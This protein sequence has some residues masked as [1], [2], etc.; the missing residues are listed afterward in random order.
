MAI[1]IDKPSNQDTAQ[2][3]YDMYNSLSA[4]TE[5]KQDKLISGEN[6][7]TI[8]GESILGSGDIEIQGGGGAVI[9]LTQAEYNEITPESGITY[10]ITDSESI[11]MNDYLTVD[12][13]EATYAT[14]DDLEE[15]LDEKV[16]K[17]TTSQNTNNYRFAKWNADGLVT[18]DG[19]YANQVT[20]KV[21]GTN[22]YDYSNS[23][24]WPEIYAPVTAGTKDQILL[25]N[26]SGAP[27]WSNIKFVFLSQSEYDDLGT[28]DQTTIY[29]ITSDE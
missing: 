17:I 14:L 4:I 24:N 29:F 19:G 16:S 21:N 18:G 10:I 20:K 13:A 25:S 11:D 5:G 6:I 15:G 26:G 1:R 7:K 12:D 8:N 28:Y 27:V 22:Y 3:R 23:T 9:E 2:I